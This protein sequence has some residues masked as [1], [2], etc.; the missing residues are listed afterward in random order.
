DRNTTIPTSRSQIFS[1][2]ADNQT[3]VEV[4]VLQGERELAR[5][6]R[7]LGRFH[8]DGIAPAPRGM[9]QIEVTFDIDAN[10]ILNVKAQDKG[11][12]RE[13]SVT[14]T[15]SSTL[16]KEEV[17]RL[18]KE[19]EA[20]S[21]EDRRKRE[22][23]ETR[24]Q[25]DQMVYQAEKVIKENESKIPAELKTEVEAKLSAVREAAKGS[26]TDS[27]KKAM[28]ELNDSLQKIGQHIYAG[29]SDSSGTDGTAT[30]DGSD[31]KPKSEEEDVV[32]AEYKEV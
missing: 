15:A 20:N 30:G 27:L 23:V 1:T 14:I 32:D 11:T 28:D 24:N 25:A 10:G 6:N 13:Q 8:L 22:E 18:V 12:G 16:S 26:D 29:P 17:E 19:A 5:D 31:P 2:A 21:A 3:S 9:P 4:H 7:T